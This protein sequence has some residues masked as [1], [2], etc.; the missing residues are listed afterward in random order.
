MSDLH[1]AMAG[2]S[3]LGLEP[4]VELDDMRVLHS[5]QHLHLIV[6]H[7]L[8][9]LDILLEDDLDSAFAFR[10]VCLADYAICSSAECLSESV[11]GSGAVV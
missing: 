8:V 11:F 9:A 6:Y 3:Y 1:A 10:A 4:L 5:L 7:L 2:A